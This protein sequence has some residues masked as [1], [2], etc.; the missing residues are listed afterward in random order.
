M[1]NRGLALVATIV[2]LAQIAF[3]QSSSSPFTGLWVGT[4]TG[5]TTHDAYTPRM[6]IAVDE[7]GQAQGRIN[8]TLARANPA[9]P[10][11][12]GKVGLTGIEYVSGHVEG[13]EILLAGDRLDDPNQILGKDLYRL[14]LSD[15]GSTLGGITSNGGTWSGLFYAKR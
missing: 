12:R 8:W 14:V 10:R 1:L 15:D 5:G 4:W 6:E 13:R 2:L 7:R 11:Q 9:E 3:A